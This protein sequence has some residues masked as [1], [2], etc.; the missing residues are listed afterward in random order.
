MLHVSLLS[1]YEMA[2]SSDHRPKH[3]LCLVCSLFLLVLFLFLLNILAKKSEHDVSLPYPCR[4]ML[5]AANTFL[6]LPPSVGSLR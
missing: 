4:R 1:T 2:L 6:S 3:R 5:A